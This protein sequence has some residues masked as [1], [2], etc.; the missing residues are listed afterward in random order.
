[1]RI[2]PLVLL[3][4]SSAS[5]AAP[6]RVAIES[7]DANASSAELAAQ[8]ADDT[9]F[10]FEVT[11]VT[12]DQVD[13]AAELASYDVVVIGDSGHN[14]VDWTSEMATALDA[15]VQAGSGG[16]VGVGWIDF[17]YAEV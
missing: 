7:G 14:G 3:L 12:A 5:L 15:W 16:V 9:W 11:Q 6:I 10:D 2:L 4:A 17:V 13:S 1:M 8:L